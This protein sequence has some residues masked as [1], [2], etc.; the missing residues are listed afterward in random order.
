MRRKPK[1]KISN[2]I[3]LSHKAVMGSALNIA[4][5]SISRMYLCGMIFETVWSEAGRSSY[6]NHTPE[7]RLL[8]IVKNHVTGSHLFVMI[9]TPAPIMPRPHIT[10]T[11]SATATN[12]ESRFTHWVIPCAS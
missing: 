2:G 9:W 3:R 12:V 7:R 5:L 6:G 10:A 1:A 11:P 8:S 4:L